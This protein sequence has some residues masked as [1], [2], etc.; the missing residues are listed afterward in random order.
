MMGNTYVVTGTTSGIGLALVEQLLEQGCD[1][2][3]VA[4]SPERCARE[5]KR[6]RAA[7]PETRVTYVV[8][9]LSIQAEVR[10]AAREIESVLSRWGVKALDG[11]VNNAGTF[12]SRRE[13]TPEGFETQ[14]AVN[15]LAPFLLTHELLPLLERSSDARVVTVSS[16][17]HYRTRLRWKDIQLLEYYNPLRAYKQTKLANVLF[18]AQLNRRLGPDSSVHAVAADPGVV[19]TDIGQKTQCRLVRWVWALRRRMGVSPA[20]AAA[21]IAKLLFDPS[22]PG[23]PAIYWKHGKPKRPNP[24]ALNEEH[25]RRLW[26]ISARMTGVD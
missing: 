22:L 16:E 2:I 20:R 6:L 5:E 21:G 14:W 24:Y 17:S 18:T 7:Y 1:V 10:K 19:N 15:H 9:D 11:L 4:R 13:L 23:T 25:A 8:A 26:K 12:T 3:G